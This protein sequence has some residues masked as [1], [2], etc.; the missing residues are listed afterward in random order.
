M[1]LLWLHSSLS[2]LPCLPL[3][4]EVD[5]NFV[6]YFIS[7][8]YLLSKLSPGLFVYF[9]DWL[10]LHTRIGKVIAGAKYLITEYMYI[11]ASIM[12]FIH[13]SLLIFCLFYFHHASNTYYWPTSLFRLLNFISAMI[14]IRLAHENL[15]HMMIFLFSNIS[16]VDITHY[17]SWPLPGEVVRMSPDDITQNLL[18]AHS[19]ITGDR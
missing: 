15:F 19:L 3:V 18:H 5:T 14:F 4:D 17:A 13:F 12:L 2:L 1:I 7:L 9:L 10:R 8:F 16:K 11:H 6:R